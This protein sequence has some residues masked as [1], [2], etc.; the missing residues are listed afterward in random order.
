M[1]FHVRIHHWVVWWFYV[2][3][4]CGAVAVINILGRNLPR[5]EEEFI[6]LLGALFWILGGLVCYGCGGI[7]LQTPPHASEH[8]VKFGEPLQTEWHSASDFLLPGSRKSL[9]PPKH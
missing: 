6:L 7:E 5:S 1:H 2:G 8:P 3:V 4:I 9:L